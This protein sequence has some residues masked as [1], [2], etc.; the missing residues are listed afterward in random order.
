MLRDGTWLSINQTI[1][2]NND[3]LDDDIVVESSFRVNQSASVTTVS[4]D[5]VLNNPINDEDIITLSDSDDN[6]DVPL[7]LRESNY[8]KN[9]F[10]SVNS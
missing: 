1:K 2:Q 5:N 6:E 8:F 7:Q 4:T 9:S 3:N 10:I